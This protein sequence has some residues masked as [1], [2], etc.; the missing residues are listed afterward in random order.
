MEVVTIT[1]SI[2][3]FSA[4]LNIILLIGVRNLLKQNEQLEDQLTSLIED[5]R[6]KIS[7]SLENMRNIDQRGMFEKDDEVGA[8]FDEIKKVIEDLDNQ[9]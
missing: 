9:I 8:S 3:L 7:N 5:V 2:I 1:N 4:L 6:Y